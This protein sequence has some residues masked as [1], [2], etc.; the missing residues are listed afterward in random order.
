M[1]FQRPTLP[2]L[3]ER[4]DADL[5]SRLTKQQLRRSNAKVYGRVVAGVAHGLYGYAEWLSRQLFVDTAETEFLD[6]F[7]SL[8]GAA[9]K[10]AAKA[11]GQVVFSFTGDAVEIPTGT[12]LQ[13]DNNQQYQT[14]SAVTADGSAAVEALTAGVDG[15]LDEGETLTM[16][17]PVAGVLSEV[18]SQGLAG[19]ADAESDENL[20]SRILAIIQDRPQGGSAADYVAWALEVEGVTRAWC[21]PL[22]NGLGTVAVRFVCDDLDDIIPTAEMV[23]KVQGHI[24]ALRPV[25]AMLTVSAPLTLPV[26]ITIASLIP[27]DESVRAAVE[28]ELHDLF[29]RE[30]EPGARLYVSHIRQAISL[31]AGETD[32]T[33]VSPTADIVPS[34][35]YLPVLGDVTWQS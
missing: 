27:D 6:R 1:S 18:S 2:A 13:G 12:V 17:S 7:A 14:V 29:S 31:A 34:T 16:V 32:H 23:Q 21:Y 8:Y 26:D 10:Q 30:G 33:L 20:R 28:S 9:R 5:E 22:E 3:I 19:G 35:G 15:N 11:S 25:T 24:D 4:I